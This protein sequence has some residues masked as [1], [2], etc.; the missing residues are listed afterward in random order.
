MLMG[1]IEPKTTSKHPQKTQAINTS[2]RDFP[3][4]PSFPLGTDPEIFASNFLFFFFDGGIA[5]PHIFP[6][7]LR[8]D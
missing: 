5:G 8:I 7:L 4:I 6:K 1:Y 2:D 3:G